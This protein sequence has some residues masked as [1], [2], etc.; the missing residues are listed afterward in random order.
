LGF[1]NYL[2]RFLPHLSDVCEPLRHLTDG[3]SIWDWQSSQD[4]AFQKIKQLVTEAPFLR[5]YNVANPVTLQCDS[6]DFGLGA[7]LLQLGQPM[8]FVRLFMVVMLFQKPLMMTPKRLQSMRLRLR[9]YNLKVSYI[10]G[11]DLHITNFHSRSPLPLQPLDSTPSTEC[12]FQATKLV[13][14]AEI[15]DD[16]EEVNAAEFMCATDDAKNRMR[17]HVSDDAAM[18]A[19]KQ[20]VL[21]G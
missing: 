17:N 1:V 7:T 6:S 3:D 16:F 15:F 19:L 12:V 2:A 8:A 9:D 18:Q 5:Y 20:I 10:P 11:R 14:G 4:M 21:T 13:S